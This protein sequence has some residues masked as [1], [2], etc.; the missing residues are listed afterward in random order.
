MVDKLKFKNT[1]LEELKD[2]GV[3]LDKEASDLLTEKAKS[4]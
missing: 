3:F 1:V 2:A 4:I